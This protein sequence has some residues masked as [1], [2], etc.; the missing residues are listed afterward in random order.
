VTPVE[1]DEGLSV[2][3]SVVD[4]HHRKLIELI[5]ALEAAVRDPG[6]ARFEPVLKELE[7]YVG[8]HLHYEEEL[9]QRHGYP[10][11]DA[12]RAQHDFMRAEVAK[13]RAGGGKDGATEMLAF[14]LLWF[15]GHIEA[16]DRRYAGFLKAAGK[17]Y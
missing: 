2:G 12:H 13:I 16:E 14:L 6:G 4:A 9:L 7:R 1:W 3:S 10:A 8:I 15:K 5:A 11:L 17:E